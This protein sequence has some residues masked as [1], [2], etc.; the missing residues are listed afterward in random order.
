M[1]RGLT[2]Q[3]ASGT[4]LEL[5]SAQPVQLCLAALINSQ[6]LRAER[7]IRKPKAQSLNL[8][9]KSLRLLV[10]TRLFQGHAVTP[11]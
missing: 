1:G 3:S 2:L 6:S 11:Q 4:Y 10:E 7:D 8:K 9:M 5:C